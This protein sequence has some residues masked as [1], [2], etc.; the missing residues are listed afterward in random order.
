MVSIRWCMYRPLGSVRT[1]ARSIRAAVI[2]LTAQPVIA[3]GAS[4]V[5]IA[6]T[7]GAADPAAH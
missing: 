4:E 6:D 1:K 5:I 3:A 7:I 2:E